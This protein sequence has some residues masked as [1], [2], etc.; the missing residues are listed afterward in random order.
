MTAPILS[1]GKELEHIDDDI[2][3]AGLEAGNVGTFQAASWS[4]QQAVE[5]LDRMESHLKPWMA[6]EYESAEQ[7]MLKRQER[8]LKHQL[9]ETAK[10]QDKA[11]GSKAAVDWITSI[12]ERLPAQV[13]ESGEEMLDSAVRS[14]SIAVSRGLAACDGLTQV[15]KDLERLEAKKVEIGNR[16]ACVEGEIR[17]E[18]AQRLG[19]IKRTREILHELLIVSS[20]VLEVDG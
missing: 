18:E 15:D 2:L 5:L 17:R 11:K 16:L 4:S 19:R 12:A 7:A 10:K 14:I 1:G 8:Q 6:S 13:G 20:W 9:Q 3:D